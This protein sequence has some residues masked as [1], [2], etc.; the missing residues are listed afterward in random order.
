MSLSFYLYDIVSL[1]G[2]APSEIELLWKNITHNLN[3][4]AEAAGIYGALWRPEENGFEAAKD[5]IPVLEAGLARLKADPEH[6][7]QFNAENG[8]GLYKH[9]VPF[10]E[11]ILEG[12]K[13]YP[14]AYL[15]TCR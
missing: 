12:C 3:T 15:R 1:G 9:F 13:K 11:E 2:A 4:M 6:F 7:K 10:V 8:W 5:L 14:K